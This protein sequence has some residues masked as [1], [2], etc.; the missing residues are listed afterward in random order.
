MAVICSKKMTMATTD[1]SLMP[2]MTSSMNRVTR[3]AVE[4]IML[5]EENISCR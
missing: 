5:M 4:K 1:D 3:I 2:D